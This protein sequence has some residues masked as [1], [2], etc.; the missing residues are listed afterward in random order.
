MC[1]RYSIIR[2]DKIVKMVFNVTVPTNLRLAGRWN[3]AP[4][5]MVPAILNCAVQPEL[6]MVC[7][8]LIPSWAKDEKVGYKMI[9]ARAETLTEKPAFRTSLAKRRCLIPA[10]GFYEW[11][12]HADGTKTP[13]YIRL[14]TRDLL[15]FAGLWETWRTPSGEALRSCTIITTSPN[16]LTRTIHDRM[17][18]IIPR[19]GYLDWLAPDA[20]SPAHAM[21]WLRPYP[22]EEME[23][24]TVSTQ[25]NSAKNEGP[26]L[27]EPV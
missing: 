13:K 10:D 3:V 20:M 7:W 26:Q 12:K 27:V 1:G 6:A 4:S 5:Q 19:E 11:Q 18:A 16:E 2:G 23:A 14:K 15:A 24:L 22:A 21:D 8:G 9:N 17:P 25:V